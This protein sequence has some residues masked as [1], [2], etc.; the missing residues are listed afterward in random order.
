MKKRPEKIFA[1]CF[2]FLFVCIFT[3]ESAFVYIGPGAGFAFISSFFVFFV[4]SLLAILTILFWP[5][6]FIVKT[7]RKKKRLNS[8]Y[9]DR[10]VIILGLDGMDPGITMKFMKEG[11]FPISTKQVNQEFFEISER[12]FYPCHL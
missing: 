12:L 4:S 1:L 5:I 6:H 3:S 11:N 2:S 8:K 10:R 7:I 9:G